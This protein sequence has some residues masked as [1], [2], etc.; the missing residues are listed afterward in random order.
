M[1]CVWCV[2]LPVRPPP[3]TPIAA[4]GRMIGGVGCSFVAGAAM[5]AVVS[6]RLVMRPRRTLGDARAIP[7]SRSQGHV[8]RALA[9]VFATRRGKRGDVLRRPSL[10]EPRGD[11]ST[12]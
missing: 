7:P 4:N 2:M 10:R 6:A 8:E 11:L 1:M 12:E 3:M 5:D 9:A